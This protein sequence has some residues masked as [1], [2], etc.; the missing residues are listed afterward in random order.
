[1]MKSFFFS[2]LVICIFKVSYGQVEVLN[3]G[4]TDVI[5]SLS[6]IDNNI[7]IGGNAGTLLK[8]YDEGNQLTPVNLPQF[9]LGTWTEYQRIDTNNI[10]LFSK[11]GNYTMIYRSS[12]GG[13]TWVNKLDTDS[14]IGMEFVMFDSLQGILMC[15][16]H[17]CLRTYDGG[18]TWQKDTLPLYY[19]FAAQRNG[20]S[21][22]IASIQGGAFI[23]HDRGNTWAYTYTDNL[24]GG[25]QRDF[26]YLAPDTI[27]SV[28]GSTSGFFFLIVMMVESIGH[29]IYFRRVLTS[30]QMLSTS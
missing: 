16:S 20:D 11:A 21:T 5:N 4:A 8:S 15:L 3:T 23:S 19:T 2:F 30:L 24:S 1:M 6:I 17:K 27:Y 29:I 28:S 13:Q 14:I 25:T 12:D 26:Y 9:P 10:F 7:M 18:D 22:I